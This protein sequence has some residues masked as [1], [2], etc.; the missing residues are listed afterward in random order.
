MMIR[1]VA[2]DGRTFFYPADLLPSSWHVTMP[3]IMAYDV[4]P[5]DSLAEKAAILARAVAENWHIIFEHDPMTACATVKKNETGRI[6]V[7]E[8]FADII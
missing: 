7:D 2:D 4:R 6:V 1:L 8:R 5:L 3:Y